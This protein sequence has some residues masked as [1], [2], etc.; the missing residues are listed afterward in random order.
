MRRS[1]GLRIF[2]E[3]NMESVN[4]TD[5]TLMIDKKPIHVG[6][7][8][9]NIENILIPLMRKLTDMQ[10]EQGRR[11]VVF[12][13]APIGSGKSVTASFL[14][15]LSH[16]VPD[17]EPI[18]ALG[19]DGFHYENAYLTTHEIEYQGQMHNMKAVKGWPET[20]NA[21]KV[22]EKIVEL[23]SKETVL[24]PIYDRNIHDPVDDQLCITAKIVIIEGLWMM[25]DKGPWKKI[26]DLAD[27]RIMLLAP[28]FVLRK[29]AVARKIRNGMTPEAAR[30]YCDT[31]DCRATIRILDN[32][33]DADLY[34]ESTEDATLIDL[35][36]KKPS[37]EKYRP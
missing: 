31:S 13:G 6:F 12:L 29:R 16:V 27:Y 35:G 4:Y 30:A 22:Y 7:S 19:L 14:E 23:Q 28:F 15:K 9:E 25:Y 18:Q 1:Q 5:T 10:R 20:F 2:S 11:I 37:I 17:V 3:K 34:L 21:Q 26:Q 8:Q 32:M 33:A 24:C 36:D